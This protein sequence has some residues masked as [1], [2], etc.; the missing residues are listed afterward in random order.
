MATKEKQEKAKAAAVQLKTPK[1]TR[2][3]TGAD[4]IIRD[5]IL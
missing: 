3:W 1:G 4:S 5:E 2:D